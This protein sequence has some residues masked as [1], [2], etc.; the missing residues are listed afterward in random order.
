MARVVQGLHLARISL[1][2]T[3]AL[4]AVLVWQQGVLGT[5]ILLP[6]LLGWLA[7]LWWLRASP[8]GRSWLYTAGALWLIATI[9]LLTGESIESASGVLGLIALMFVFLCTVLFAMEV[10]E[11]IRRQDLQLTGAV[12]FLGPPLL[13][14]LTARMGGWQLLLVLAAT[15]VL[16]SVFLGKVA[17]GAERLT[18]RGPVAPGEP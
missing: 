11:H 3:L 14:A 15:T 8:V 16:Y 10:S 1:L 5:R 6:A 7:P 12:L 4:I 13:I 9:F 2:L 17:Q 18:G